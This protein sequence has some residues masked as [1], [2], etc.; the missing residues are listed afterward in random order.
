MIGMLGA[1]CGVFL[2][3]YFKMKSKSIKISISKSVKDMS[4]MFILFF[5]CFILAGSFFVNYEKPKMSNKVDIQQITT[6]TTTP[7][8]TSSTKY[9]LRQLNQLQKRYFLN[10]QMRIKCI[11]TI[12]NQIINI[13]TGIIPKDRRAHLLNLPFHNNYGDTLIW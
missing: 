7:A 12:R 10:D 13:F 4:K 1:D 9:S 2:Y 3:S 11:Q 8:E 6:D 5:L